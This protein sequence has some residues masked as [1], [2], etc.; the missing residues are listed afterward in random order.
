MIEQGQAAGIIQL[1][2]RIFEFVVLLRIL[3]S[4]FRIPPHNEFYRLI[5]NLTEP[6]LKPFRLTMIVGNA[7]V[8]FSPLILLFLLNLAER[9]LVELILSS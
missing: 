5:Y 8:D 4:W 1:I 2:F 9:F 6:L 3:F 7:G